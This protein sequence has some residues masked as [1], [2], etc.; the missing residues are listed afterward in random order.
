M[1]SNLETTFLWNRSFYKVTCYCYHGMEALLPWHLLLPW[2][3]ILF[4]L[5]SHNVVIIMVWNEAVETWGRFFKLKTLYSLYGRYSYT[6][7]YISLYRY[8]NHI[9][10]HLSLFCVHNKRHEGIVLSHDC[11]V[12]DV[13]VHF[14]QK[15]F[16]R[17]SY[18]WWWSY[19]E[20]YIPLEIRWL[21]R[22]CMGSHFSVTP[23]VVVCTCCKSVPY[24]FYCADDAKSFAR[25][26]Q[27]LWHHHSYTILRDNVQTAWEVLTSWSH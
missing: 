13:S 17:Y 24:V 21:T 20:S 5:L 18:W 19:C 3:P 23:C 8:A 15:V 9:K 27:Y 10:I 12:W 26:Q 1:L 7:L 16:C 4:R 22:R 14:I 6:V 2:L 25:K 11:E